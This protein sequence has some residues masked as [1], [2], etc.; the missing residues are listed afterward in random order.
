MMRDEEDRARFS[1]VKEGKR[2]HTTEG[3]TKNNPSECATHCRAHTNLQYVYS[4]F[5]RV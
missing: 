3:N 5:L 1:E 4:P 2:E